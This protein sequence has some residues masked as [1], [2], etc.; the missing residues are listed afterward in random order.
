[1]SKWDEESLNRLLA[2]LELELTVNDTVQ[3]LIK[4]LK[5]GRRR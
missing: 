2:E 1:M 4:E 3:D 5:R